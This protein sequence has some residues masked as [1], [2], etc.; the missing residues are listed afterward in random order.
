MRTCAHRSLIAGAA[1]SFLLSIPLSAVVADT[2]SSDVV[3]NSLS[4][5]RGSS[6]RQRFYAA[7][8]LYNAA[9]DA[10]AAAPDLVKMLPM[11]A[12]PEVRAMIAQAI[13]ATSAHFD[14]AVPA[15]VTALQHDRA[16]DVRTRAARALGRLGLR[17]A[18]AVPALLATLKDRS[19]APLR[20][21]AAHA[22]GAKGFAD[23]ANEIAPALTAALSDDGS[24]VAA[25]ASDSLRALGPKAVAALPML[26][27][28]LIRA[29]AGTSTNMVYMVLLVLGELGPAGATAE[30]DCL[31]A[32]VSDNP[33]VRVEAAG[34]LLAF[35]TSTREAMNTLSSALA[36]TSETLGADVSWDRSDVVTRAAVLIGLHPTHAMPTLLP[37][38][39]A[40]LEDRDPDVRRFAARS[41]D[42]VLPVMAAARSADRETALNETRQILAL[43][44]ASDVSTRIV[45]VDT[46]L[47]AA[48]PVQGARAAEGASLRGAGN[49]GRT[50]P[51]RVI[52]GPF[53]V[54][55]GGA[56]AIATAGAILFRRRLSG[57]LIRRPKVRVFIS[58]RRQDSEAWC[59]RIYDH[60]VEQFGT[61]C[62]FR[63]IDSLAPGDVFAQRILECLRN[64][65]A[66]IALIGNSWLTSL[67]T[68]GHPRL[69]DPADFV[70]TELS[71]ACVGGKAV[72]PVLVDGA[73][74]PRA[75]DLPSELRFVS[76]ANALQVSDQHFA[77]DMRILIAALSRS[78]NHS[79]SDGS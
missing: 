51:D 20:E 7:E 36:F 2:T 5:L 57:W 79:A 54:V 8:S 23:Y 71:Q 46:A 28:L 11:E 25:A 26:R 16:P 78:R 56:A 37:R 67:D 41:F 47:H 77:I 34:A 69:N 13:G 38:L 59:G 12:D 72:F 24:G 50:I 22:L 68:D 74:M 21:Q 35:G 63:D 4:N 60:L 61:A 58:Y 49:V 6:V 10:S 73:T 30:P 64:C 32:L 33:A 75:A 45:A 52:T 48:A 9:D 27:A 66:V 65:D 42:Q 19:N 39:A 17:G 40:L 44:P 15:L 55:L 31:V 76:R 53:L 3:R 70:R 14:G 1:L 18:E 62:V 43:M 29:N